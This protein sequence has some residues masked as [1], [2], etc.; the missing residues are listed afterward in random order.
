TAGADR[1][2]VL[3]F[4]APGCVGHA[5]WAAGERSGDVRWHVLSDSLGLSPGTVARSGA[6]TA[7]RG[8]LQRAENGCVEYVTEWSN[9]SY[10]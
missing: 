7:T 2:S 8:H 3:A 1:A 5:A 10:T 9:G 6:L 4:P